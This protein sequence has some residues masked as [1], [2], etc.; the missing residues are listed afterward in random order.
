MLTKYL[1]QLTEIA[2]FQEVRK[3]AFPAML[4]CIG[5]F[6]KEYSKDQII[7]LTENNRKLVGIVLS[8]SVHM[9]QEDIWGNRAILLD[10][11]RNELFGET[12]ACGGDNVDNV[13]FLAMERTVV[14]MLPFVRIMHTCASACDHHQ[15]II[16]N[17]VTLIARKNARLMTKI[18]V[19]SKNTL[20]E[21]LV[22]YL[23]KQ[24]E[25]QHHELSGSMIFPIHICVPLGR[26]QLAE[27]LHAN[28]S[29][30]FRELSRMK[31]EGLIDFEKKEFFI[32]KELN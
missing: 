9:I 13:S 22:A 20:R 2:L 31:E 3:E 28:R 26:Q 23:T 8:G 10:I 11:S 24:I 15:R 19:I 12:F 30:V 32:L 27:Y 7:H 29:A 17:M 18:D 5:A 1:D 25:E 6:V 16:M 21:K 4:S 14:L